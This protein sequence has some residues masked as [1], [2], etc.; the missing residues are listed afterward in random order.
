LGE[1]GR[2]EAQTM[3]TQVNKCKNEKIKGEKKKN[4]KKKLP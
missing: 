1:R 2:E 4:F 3:H